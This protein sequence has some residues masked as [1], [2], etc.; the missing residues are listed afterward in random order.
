MIAMR[1]RAFQ[2]MMCGYGCNLR[3]RRRGRRLEPSLSSDFANKALAL[4]VQKGRDKLADYQG[5]VEKLK[6][7]IERLG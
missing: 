1:H 4:V 3:A 2:W 6:E 7:Q 5:K